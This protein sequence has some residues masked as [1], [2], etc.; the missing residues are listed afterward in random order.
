[1]SGL[2]HKSKRTVSFVEFE[3]LQL[4]LHN[5]MTASSTQV[6]VHVLFLPHINCVPIIR[7]KNN[8]ER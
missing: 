3:W 8:K 1:M 6:K 2:E 5:K 4:F 7:R